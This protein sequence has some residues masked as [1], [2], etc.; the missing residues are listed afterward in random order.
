V[1]HCAELS[2]VA[3]YFTQ[4]KP[5]KSMVLIVTTTVRKCNFCKNALRTSQYKR[6]V[7]SKTV[8]APQRLKSVGHGQFYHPFSFFPNGFLPVFDAVTWHAIGAY[9]APIT[10]QVTAETYSRLVTYWPLWALT[11][12]VRAQHGKTSFH[13]PNGF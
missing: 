6:Y 11:R 7:H 9:H 5:H 3:W 10:F 13:F 12:L 8:H 4:A 2:P 1:C